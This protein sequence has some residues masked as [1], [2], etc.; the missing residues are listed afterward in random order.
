MAWWRPVAIAL[1]VVLV[2]VAFVLA[3]PY[4]DGI[5]QRDRIAKANKD[6]E[7]I[8]RAVIAYASHAGRLPSTLSDLHIE[9]KNET[10]AIGGPF[11]RAT[12]QPPAGWTAE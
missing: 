12:P 6:V 1:G 2:L 7:A 8:A 11:L 5:Q 3:I 4:Y 9:I 10:G